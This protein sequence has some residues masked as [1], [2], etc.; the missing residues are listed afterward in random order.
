[1]QIFMLGKSLI[2]YSFGYVNYDALENWQKSNEPIFLNVIKAQ[3]C[4]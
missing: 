3:V 4:Y 2:K 1:M